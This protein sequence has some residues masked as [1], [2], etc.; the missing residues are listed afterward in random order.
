M[1]NNFILKT[2]SYK[3]SHWPVLDPEVTHS[4][5]YFESRGGRYAGTISFGHQATLMEHFLGQQVTQEKIDY[6]HEFLRQHFGFDL[7]NRAGWEHI[8]SKHEGRLPLEIKAVAEGTYVP[9]HNV[10]MTVENTDPKVPW[11]TN[12]AETLLVQD[13]YPLTIASNS[14]SCRNIMLDFLE[15]TGDPSRIDFMLHDFGFRGVTCWEQAAIGGM[16]HLLMFNGTDTLAAIEAAKHYYDAPMCGFS[17][18]ATEH[19]VMTMRGRDQEAAVVDALLDA[20]PEGLVACV[21]DQY[22]IFEFCR[23]LS[24]AHFKPRILGRNG[25]FVVRPDSGSPP[26]VVCK[27]LEILWHGFGGT[28]NSKGYK[29]LDP[30]IRVIQGD[31]IDHQMIHIVLAAMMAH[32]FS[33]DNI[34]FG[35]GG[36]LLQKFDRDTNRFA[37]KCSSVQGSFGQRDVYKDPITDMV[38][39]SKRGRLSLIKNGQGQFQTVP[40]HTVDPA[41][42]F[43][44]TVFLNG[45]LVNRQNWADIVGRARRYKV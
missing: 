24:N 2:D 32:G 21:G 42:D 10:L 44:Q 1:R 12:Y 33:A 15:K 22:N 17:I 43:L 45:E 29:V 35:S 5:S 23:M 31:G 26:E 16:A 30:H 18:P 40:Q 11:L 14:N 9:A 38:K 7:M 19:F 13:W 20:Y 36:G 28:F 3:P 34:A 37:F 8:L 4:Y 25:T 39:T 41:E 27:V 6:A